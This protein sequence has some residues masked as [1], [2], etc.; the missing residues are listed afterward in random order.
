MVKKHLLLIIF[1][2]L[3]LSGFLFRLYLASQIPHAPLFDEGDYL[4]FAKRLSQG[5]FYSH[6]CSRTYGYPLFLFLVFKIF[7]SGNLQAI[8]F[9]QAIIDT[10]TGVLLFLLSKKIYQNLKISLLILTIYMFNPLTASFTGL[11]LTEVWALFLLTLFLFFLT[12]PPIPI[13]LFMNGIIFGL[14]TFTRIMFFYWSVLFCLFFYF[15]G[16]FSI[17]KIKKLILIIGFL[18]TFIYPIISNYKMY[19]SL[20]PL[21]RMPLA[22]LYFYQSFDLPRWPSIL[23]ENFALTANKIIEPTDFKSPKE[24]RE[25]VLPKIQQKLSNISIGQFFLSRLRIIAFIWDKSNLYYYEDPFYPKDSLLLRVG[26]IIFMAFSL[27]GVIFLIL[28]KGKSR[29]EKIFLFFSLSL[30]FYVTILLSF[31]VPEERLT[32]PVYPTLLLFWVCTIKQITHK[33]N[34]IRLI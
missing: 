31:F 2:F 25:F 24:L 17:N 21:P 4:D 22:L 8:I 32:L 16:L 13:F 19:N 11:F 3:I 10:I 33:I 14:F 1:Y 29:F 18:L 7:G 23:K 27:L 15:S 28:K 5:E 20:S 34:K 12:I 6:C 9:S 26:N 30:L